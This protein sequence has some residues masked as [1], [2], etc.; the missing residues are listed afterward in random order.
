M[1]ITSNDL[2]CI[3]MESQTA[4]RLMRALCLALN[5]DYP[6]QQMIDATWQEKR[7]AMEDPFS[8]EGAPA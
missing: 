5:L 3:G 7:D 1:K 2:Y 8:T 6:P 4:Y